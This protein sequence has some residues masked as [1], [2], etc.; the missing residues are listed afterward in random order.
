M[1]PSGTSRTKNT[2]PVLEPERLNWCVLGIRRRPSLFLLGNQRVHHNLG[3]MDVSA[4]TGALILLL[5][6]SIRKIAPPDNRFLY[7]HV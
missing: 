3:G 4:K 7:R 5:G 1:A 2:I 6:E